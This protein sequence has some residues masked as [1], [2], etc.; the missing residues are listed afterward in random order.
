M[1]LLLRPSPP[2][3]A[4]AG[5]GMGAHPAVRIASRRVSGARAHCR[6]KYTGPQHASLGVSSAARTSSHRARSPTA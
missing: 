4:R 6:R 1:R 5:G 2:V 3:M